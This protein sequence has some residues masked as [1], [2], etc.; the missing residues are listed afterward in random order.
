MCCCRGRPT[1]AP[2]PVKYLKP[3]IEYFKTKAEIYWSKW[4]N[5]SKL[6]SRSRINKQR[7][8]YSKHEKHSSAI[9]TSHWLWTSVLMVQ[10]TGW[11]TVNGLKIIFMTWDYTNGV[12]IS[13]KPVS[14]EIGD[15]NVVFRLNQFLTQYFSVGTPTYQTLHVHD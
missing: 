15:K 6:V 7:L 4:V 13:V 12:S 9:S 2:G 3:V 10:Y 11:N 1:L 5:P 14:H 8:K